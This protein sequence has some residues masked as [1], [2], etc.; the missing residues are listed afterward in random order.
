MGVFVFFRKSSKTQGNLVQ[1]DSTPCFWSPR[2]VLHLPI[3]LLPFCADLNG[4]AL[5]KETQ[6]PNSPMS[7]PPAFFY[8]IIIFS[9]H[10]DSNP[11]TPK[12]L[13]LIKGKTGTVHLFPHTTP[14]L[15]PSITW[16]VSLRCSS[17]FCVYPFIPKTGRLGKVNSLCCPAHCIHT[18]SIRSRDYIRRNGMKSSQKFYHL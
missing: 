6:S 9:I 10:L 15:S 16:S 17:V 5:K 11:K 3:T 2:M 8:N 18:G 13:I 4:T 7:V 1:S 12:N 14:S